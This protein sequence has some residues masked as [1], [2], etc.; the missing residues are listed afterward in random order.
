MIVGNKVGAG[1]GADGSWTTTDHPDAV[2]RQVHEALADMGAE[3]S[4]LTYLR[5]AGDIPG[6]R[7][8]VP[9]ED[10]LG[11]LVDCATKG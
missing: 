4:E 1:R 5:L 8:D 10:S 11:V 9:L 7:S 3:T 2:R 6:A